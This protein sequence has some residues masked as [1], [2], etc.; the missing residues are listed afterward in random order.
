[1]LVQPYLASVERT[2][3][4]SVVLVDGEPTHAVRKTPVRG[5]FRIQ[6]Q[7][8]GRYER[9]DLGGAGAEPAAL[10]RWV[11]EAAGHELLYARVDLLLDENDAWQLAELEVTEPDLYLALAPD[12]GTVL[13]E[14][15]LARA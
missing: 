11:V 14:A 1:V 15:T 8:G 6:E 5:E 2:G 10:A 9:L 3:E 4:V 7:Y 12:V 13:A